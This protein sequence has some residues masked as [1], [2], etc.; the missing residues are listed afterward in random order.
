MQSVTAEQ[1]ADFETEEAK[2][3]ATVI[4]A[5]SETD[6]QKRQ[7]YNDFIQHISS[8]AIRNA[9]PWANN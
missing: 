3:K 7:R 5:A 4:A 1:L 9:Y 8:K 6:R 2:L